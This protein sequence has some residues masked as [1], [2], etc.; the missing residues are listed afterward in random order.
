MRMCAN[1]LALA[2]FPA[3]GDAQCAAEI[4]ARKA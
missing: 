2:G 3:V 4:A 1:A